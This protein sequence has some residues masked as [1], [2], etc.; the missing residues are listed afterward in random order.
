MNK[1]LL[2]ESRPVIAVVTTPEMLAQVDIES[3]RNQYDVQLI[4]RSA[5]SGEELLEILN[6]CIDILINYDCCRER[7]APIL[8]ALSL[9][10]IRAISVDM[11]GVEWINSDAAIKLGIQIFSVSNY[12]TD[13]V[14]EHIIAEILLHAHRIHQSYMDIID[15]G[16]PV[17][18]KGWLL[19]CK[20]VGILG[21]GNIGKR[22]AEILTGFGCQIIG[23]NRTS[24]EFSGEYFADSEEVISNAQILILALKTVPDTVGFLSKKRLKMLPSGAIVINQMSLEIIDQE[25]LFSLLIS[26]HIG[27]YSAPRGGTEGQAIRNTNLVT[28]LPAN[29]WYCEESQK[30]LTYRWVENLRFGLPMYRSENS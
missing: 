5:I 21:L 24:T 7:T 17:N 12:C 28:Y 10:G 22:V 29:A 13:S 25:A 11:T 3:L 8:Y 14:S 1:E 30:N 6:P 27:G 23:W 2:L 9:K 26:K 20:T 15:G 16:I 19:K 4:E 18:R